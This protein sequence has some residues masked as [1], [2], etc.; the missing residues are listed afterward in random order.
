MNTLLIAL[1]MARRDNPVTRVPSSHRKAADCISK[2]S[3]LTCV[4]SFWRISILFGS[5]AELRPF[6]VTS[7]NP[8]SQLAVVTQI[9]KMI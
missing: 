7:P 2:A 5:F 4:L 1:F 9:A 8:A 6:T 3:C